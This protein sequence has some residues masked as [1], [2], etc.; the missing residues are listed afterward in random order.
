MIADFLT[1]P[2]Q[3]ALFR[4]FRDR[5][6]NVDPL[7][8]AQWTGS[9]ECVEK[10]DRSESTDVPN[11]DD[12]WTIVP[13]KRTRASVKKCD[14]TIINNKRVAMSSKLLKQ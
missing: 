6:M 11:A 8:I 13:G 2:L 3:G 1:K 9:Q 5:I 12:G 4:K 7:T 10:N 14:D